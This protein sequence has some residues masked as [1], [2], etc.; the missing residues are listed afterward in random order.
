MANP[1]PVPPGTKIDPGQLPPP[2]PPLP[3][4]YAHTAVDESVAKPPEVH[5]NPTLPFPPKS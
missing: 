1:P 4:P 2:L 5:Q 3:A